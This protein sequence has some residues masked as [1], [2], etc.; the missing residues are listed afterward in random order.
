M[1]VRVQSGEVRADVRRDIAKLAH[2]DR[3][4]GSGTVQ[5]GLVHGFG[6]G[7]KCAIATTVAHDCHNLLVVGTDDAQ[8]A[9]AVNELTACSGGQVVVLDGAVIGKVALPIAGL[10]SDRPA[11]EV[12]LAA[13]SVLEGFR[14][15]GCRLHNPNM[16]LSL[17]GLVVIPQL[18]L[19]DKGLV[20]VNRFAVIRVLE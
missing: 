2:L 17:L 15:C 5:L 10:M 8:M 9:I 6:F 18:R 19:S 4:Q 20:D 3:H 7:E 14:K 1:K 11:A 16:Q 12:A 13:A